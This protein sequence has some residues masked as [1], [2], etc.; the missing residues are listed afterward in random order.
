MKVISEQAKRN[1]VAKHIYAIELIL[2]AVGKFE[3]EF[4]MVDRSFVVVQ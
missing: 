2:E 3:M 4:V 1:A